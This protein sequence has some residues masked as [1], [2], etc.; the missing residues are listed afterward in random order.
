MEFEPTVPLP[1]Q[2]FPELTDS[3]TLAPLR[4]RAEPGTLSSGVRKGAQCHIMCATAANTRFV[5]DPR[6]FRVGRPLAILGLRTFSGKS[7]F[8]GLPTEYKSL[9]RLGVA[10]WAGE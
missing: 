8:V 5:Q 3:A 2:Q 1:V 6:G 4:I 7:R 10:P 9:Q